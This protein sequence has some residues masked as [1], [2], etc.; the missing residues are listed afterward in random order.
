ML[1]HSNDLPDTAGDNFHVAAI[2]IDTADLEAHPKALLRPSGRNRTSG[3]RSERSWGSNRSD[4][5]AMS[6]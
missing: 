6:A 2:Q 3:A 5:A 1:I 4:A